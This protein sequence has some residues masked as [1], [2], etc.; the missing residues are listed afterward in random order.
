MPESVVPTSPRKNA[1]RYGAPGQYTFGAMVAFNLDDVSDKELDWVILRDGGIAMYWRMTLLEEDLR[2][3]ASRDYLI[4]SFNAVEWKSEEEMHEAFLA[5][6]GF[7][8]YYGKNWNALNDCLSEDLAVPDAG[9]MVVA[10]LHFDSFARAIS[11]GAPSDYR[12]DEILLDCLARAIRY[13]S[14]LGKRLLVLLQSDDP[15]IHY[16]R[17]GGISATW[18][19]RE[20]LNEKRGL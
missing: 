7:P 3:F 12:G 11:L 4:L 16:R 19:W 13:H 6:L 10:L 18:N 2:W 8:D 14:L 9:G 15:G 1:S 5:R 20:W 17:L